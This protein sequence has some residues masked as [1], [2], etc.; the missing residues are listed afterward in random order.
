VLLL[1]NGA[2][3]VGKTTIARRYAADHPLA[4]VLDVDLIRTQLG[5]WEYH[6]AS[7]RIARELA[8]ELAR[9]HLRGGYDVVVP[10]FIG[11]PEFVA[12]LAA[13]AKETGVEFCEIVLADEPARI[14]ERFRRRRAEHAED[15][16]R[17]PE[18][19]IADHAI[20]RVVADANEGLLRE[21]ASRG[22]LVIDLRGGH[23]PAYDALRAV[24]G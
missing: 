6:D 1:V 3:A 10:Q 16:T 5:G 18:Y 20:D 13:L 11:R 7:K 23:D 24:L 17:H 4:L 8:I 14:A 12:E 21:A 2:P 19:D 22:A 15:A 9:A